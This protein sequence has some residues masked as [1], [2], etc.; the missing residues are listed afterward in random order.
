MNDPLEFL[1]KT[2]SVAIATVDGV[3]GDKPA[4]RIVDVMLHEDE[5]LYFITARGKPYYRQLKENPEIAIVGM[6]ENYVT[7]RVMGK[8]EFVDRNFVD[9][10]F[11]ANPVLK[12]V[13]PEGKRDTLEAFCLSKGVG[14]VF[15]ISVAPPK[16]ERFSFG[17]AT[18]EEPG[19]TIT[20]KCVA[21]GV[22]IDLCP[23]GAISEGDI[24][25]ID[26][27]ICLECG[28]CYDHCPH[29]AIIPASGF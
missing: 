18:V 19:Y 10:I 7:V 21:C 23:T 1:R 2:R 24:Y 16:R 26:G 20:D 17:G 15:D 4:V 14:E 3:D 8:I 11:E 25:R 22:C 5:K 29:D 28:S 12:N 13:Y 9:R 6:D 27:S